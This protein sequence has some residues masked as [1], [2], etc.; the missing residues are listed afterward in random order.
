MEVTE[1]T[2]RDLALERLPGRLES[3]KDI[4]NKPLGMLHLH[5][6]FVAEIRDHHKPRKVGL[7]LATK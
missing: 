4:E 2:L 3:W 1:T 6:F 7:P 5:G